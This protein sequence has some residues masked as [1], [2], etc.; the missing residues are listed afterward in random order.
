MCLN[1]GC[2]YAESIFDTFSHQ[3]STKP[4]QTKPDNLLHFSQRGVQYGFL[5][6]LKTFLTISAKQTFWT[7][8]HFFNS[9][10][11]YCL[12]FAQIACQSSKI[13]EVF[14][15]VEYIFGIFGHLNP[16]K[17]NQAI[18]FISTREVCNSAMCLHRGCGYA[19]SIFGTF[20]HLNPNPT[21]PNQTICYISA[22]EGC[23]VPFIGSFGLN[24]F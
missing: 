20:R 3:N 12:F 13:I 9:Y 23:K 24:C 11:F 8:L 5:R 15:Y 4:N 10:A 7:N 16:P 1:R 19:E 2:G 17:P 14:G 6:N 18:G 22:R 21:K